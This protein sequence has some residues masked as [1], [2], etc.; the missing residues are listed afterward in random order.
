VPLRSR[1][2]LVLPL[3]LA[4]CKDPPDPVTP[5]RALVRGD[6]GT[7]SVVPTAGQL[8]YCL[9]I[10]VQDTAARSLVATDD[11]ESVDCDAGKPLGPWKLPAKDDPFRAFVIFSDKKLKGTSTALQVR[12]RLTESPKAPITSMDLRAPGQV[13]IEVLDVRPAE[14]RGK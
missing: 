2:L 8:P 13:T 5:P 9:V 11:G 14:L 12:E 10:E 7:Y 3:L 1:L 4:A 6:G